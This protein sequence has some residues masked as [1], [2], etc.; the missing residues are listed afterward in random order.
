MHNSKVYQSNLALLHHFYTLIYLRIITYSNANAAR[1]FSI[2][3][4]LSPNDMIQKFGQTAPKNIQEACKSTVMSI[5]GNLPNYAL[6]ASLL[7]TST[8]LANLLYQMQLTGYMFKNAEYRISLTRSLK[9]LPRL[10]SSTVIKQGNLTISNVKDVEGDVKVR[11]DSGESV[12]LPV[13]EL[14][15]ALSE[16]INELRMELALLR[17]DRENE[18][19]SNM[20][21]YIQAMPES[22]LAKLT[23]DMSDDVIQAIQ[24]LVNAVME[25]L[26]IDTSAGDEVII[27]QS[28]G[29]LAQL[30]MWQLIL[31]YKLRELEALDKGVSI[32]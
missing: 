26:G 9:G 13:S 1:Y 8:K 12:S 2:V 32:N 10:P 18:L 17:N 7:T 3:E 22:E 21:T 29:P 6:D 14:T 5:L 23:T 27:Q 31:G 25:K 28:V 24:M 15:G 20:L 19:R 11:A 16:E 4:K 30:C